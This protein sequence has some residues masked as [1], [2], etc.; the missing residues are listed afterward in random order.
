[1]MQQLAD[2]LSSRR[3]YDRELCRQ[4]VRDTMAGTVALE[5]LDGIGGD[6]VVWRVAHPGGATEKG[7]AV[8]DQQFPALVEAMLRNM[9]R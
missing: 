9:K 2:V 5:E 1:M 7:L 3:G 6:E 4:L 8:L